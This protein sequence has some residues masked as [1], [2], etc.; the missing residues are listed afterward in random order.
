[1]CK[2]NRLGDPK[3]TYSHWG[4]GQGPSQSGFL[5]S[6]GGHEDCALM[7]IHDGFRWQD[8]ECS[9]FFYHY[10][11][12]CQHGNMSILCI[13]LQCILIASKLIIHADSTR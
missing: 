7:K 1:M 2:K 12:I 4:P 8:Y 3:M 11:F 9:L 5:F 10:S 13:F 6:D